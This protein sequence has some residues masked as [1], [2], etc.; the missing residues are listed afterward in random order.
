MLGTGGWV[1]R[2]GVPLHASAFGKVFLACGAMHLP[3]G[4]LRRSRRARSPTARALEAELDRA[5]RDA[6][7]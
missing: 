5:A 2:R 4:E 6:A 1:G 7:T 3:P